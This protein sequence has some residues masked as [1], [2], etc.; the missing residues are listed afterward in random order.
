MP[1]IPSR[2]GIRSPQGA[3]LFESATAA[4]SGKPE[5]IDKA[6]SDILIKSQVQNW[7]SIAGLCF[8]SLTTSTGLCHDPGDRSEHGAGEGSRT[9]T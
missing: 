7:G 4:T 9:L 8:G 1:R 5:E 2:T 3:G 6:E